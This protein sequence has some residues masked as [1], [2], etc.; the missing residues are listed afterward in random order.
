MTPN[1]RL[2]TLAMAL[3]LSSSAAH[4]SMAVAA[5]F[6]QKVENA[7][8]IVL[9]TCLRQEARFDPTGRWIVTYSTFKVEK[10]LKG[11]PLP[12]VTVVTP[13]GAVGGVHQ[14][15]I[16]IPAFHEGAQN[17]IF[18]KDSKLGPTVLYFD[19]GAYDI[20]TDDRGEKIVTPVR[21]NLV[22]IDTQRG[23][24]VAPNDVPQPLTVFERQVDET[25]HAL[26]ENKTRMDTLAA[27]RLRQE[28]SIWSVVRQ[29]KWTILL[30]LAGVAFATWRLVR[31]S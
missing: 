25:I 28:A 5:T 10:T 17:V 13:G 27:D 11:S 3:L 29:N 15:T 4:A 16:G 18:T 26:R 20:A 23:M 1:N 9:G 19:Q 7:A 6:E 14:S 21:S 24:A 8:S 30:A 12:E 31:S 2:L 22:K